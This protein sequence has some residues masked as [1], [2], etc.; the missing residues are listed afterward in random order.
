[1][2]GRRTADLKIVRTR[3]IYKDRGE[4]GSTQAYLSDFH[5]A[6]NQVRS[7]ACDG[8]RWFVQDGRRN[9]F[10]IIGESEVPDEVKKRFQSV[11]VGTND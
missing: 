3:I 11:L 8:V 4:R 9:P 2:A 10:T 7:I 5:N 6:M 1:M